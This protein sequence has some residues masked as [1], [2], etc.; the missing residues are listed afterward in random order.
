MMFWNYF[1]PILRDYPLVYDPPTL[2]CDDWEMVQ[3]SWTFWT[4]VSFTSSLAF[5]FTIFLTCRF[6]QKKSRS[7]TKTRIQI[8]TN[9]NNSIPAGNPGSGNPNN[10][11]PLH[12]S[13]C[14]G[15]LVIHTSCQCQAGVT[16]PPNP[17]P[18]YISAKS[19]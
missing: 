12:S 17:H 1:F 16:T 2:T 6:R 3:K 14:R 8:T 13:S 15:S 19:E 7:V 11:S 18:S 4:L 10:C 5:F 9:P